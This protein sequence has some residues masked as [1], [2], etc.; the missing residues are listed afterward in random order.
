[1]IQKSANGLDVR[2]QAVW[3]RPHLRL[4]ACDGGIGGW[5][6]NGFG[7]NFGRG[8]LVAGIVEAGIQVEVK[9]SGEL[10]LA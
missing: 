4:L 6:S 5:P 9:C 7:S 1:M 10:W 3:C 8:I 2:L